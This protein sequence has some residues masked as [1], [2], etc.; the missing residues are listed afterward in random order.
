MKSKLNKS[1]KWFLMNV[2]F[3]ECI[4]AEGR[5]SEQVYIW[6]HKASGFYYIRDKFIKNKRGNAR[7]YF[8]FDGID[9]LQE[10]PETN[11]PKEKK[12]EQ[13]RQRKN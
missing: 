7:L 2:T 3:L 8:K 4:I 12:H 13:G 5:T 6:L 9:D 1:D 10:K 11:Q